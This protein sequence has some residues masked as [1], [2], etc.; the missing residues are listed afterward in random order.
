MSCV[1]RWV[2]RGECCSN[3]PSGF[4]S[5]G[6]EALERNRLY[7]GVNSET[8]QLCDLQQLFKLCASVSWK[9]VKNTH[10]RVLLDVD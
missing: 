2:G 10:L 6:R 4:L 7:S 3:L 5:W 8:Q 9:T 1:G